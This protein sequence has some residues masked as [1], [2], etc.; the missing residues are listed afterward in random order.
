MEHT[1]TQLYSRGFFELQLAFAAKVAL[2]SGC[3]LSETVGTHTNIYVRLAMGPRLDPASP[4]WMAYTSELA[5][6]RDP[7]ALTYRLYCQ[8]A[9]MRAGPTVTVSVGRFGYAHVDQDHVRLHFDPSGQ[10]PDSPLALSNQVRRR[11]EL[12]ALLQHVV[13][14]CPRVRVIG[15]SWLYNIPAYRRIFPQPYLDQLHPIE[16]PFQRMPL[17]GQFLRRDGR[18]RDDPSATFRKRLAA[19]TGV[20]DLASCFPFQ[21]LM[22]V[23][24]AAQI[25]EQLGCTWGEAE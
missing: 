24:P 21:V 5:V 10:T 3:P 9:H 12:V 15:A 22:A 16:P 25:L 8:R 7:V 23:V 6:A 20:D 13:A 2:L 1:G 18:L 17:W 14:S 11:E 19:S 4:D